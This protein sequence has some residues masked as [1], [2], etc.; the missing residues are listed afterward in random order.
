MKGDRIPSD[1]YE[2]HSQKHLLK[3]SDAIPVCRY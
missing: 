1:R 2:A 3:Q